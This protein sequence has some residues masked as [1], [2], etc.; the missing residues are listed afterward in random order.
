MAAFLLKFYTGGGAFSIFSTWRGGGAQP[1]L[2][3]EG[4]SYTY[5]C[6]VH[7]SMYVFFNFPSLSSEVYIRS[8]G[9]TLAPDDRSRWFEEE[10]VKREE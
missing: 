1:S 5:I 10:H 7:N 8:T 9:Q 2:H 4:T 3:P 6:V